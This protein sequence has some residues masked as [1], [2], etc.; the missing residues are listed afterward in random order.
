MAKVAV[1]HLPRVTVDVCTNQ[2][3]VKHADLIGAQV[4]IRGL[5]NFKDL[6]DEQILAEENRNICSRIETIWIPCLPNLMHVSSSMVKTHV[7]IEGWEEQVARSVPAT[8]VT[9]LKEKF[10]LGKARKYWMSL[11]K[12]LGNPKGSEMVLRDLLSRYGEPY[13]VYHNLSHIVAMLDE[14]EMVNENNP[15][16]ALA[17][18][19]HDVV[20]DPKDKDNEEQSA[21][22][23]KKEIQKIG[24][25]SLLGEQVNNLVMATKHTAVPVDHTAQILVDIDLIVLGKSEKEFDVYEAGI[26]KEYEW[27][28]QPDFCAGRL[29]ILQ[30][31]L[32]RP[33]IY[34]TQ[35]FRD[36]YES[37]ARKNLK[38][39]IKQLKK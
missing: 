1:A 8:V 25:P 27:V 19:F 5:R 9:K 22:L 26:R 11:M 21:E 36:K 34:S 14:L 38:K 30:S 4:I 32:D 2:Y 39:A 28:P 15:A 7:G 35:L 37:V 13:R 29:K 12:A 10:I 18:W 31:F 6:E 17:I 24:L 3:V 16:I 23:A 20:Y 33:W